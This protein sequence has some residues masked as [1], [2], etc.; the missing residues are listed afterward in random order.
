M[1]NVTD[2]VDLNLNGMRADLIAA[3]FVFGDRDGFVGERIYPAWQGAFDSKRLVCRDVRVLNNG[4][5]IVHNPWTNVIE[6]HIG[7][8][9]EIGEYLKAH[10][11]L[12]E[13]G[14]NVW[15]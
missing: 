8:V 1:N 15:D 2:N 13:P 10:G 9:A 14:A 5:L 7:S 3:G 11:R 12:C 4:T 6:D